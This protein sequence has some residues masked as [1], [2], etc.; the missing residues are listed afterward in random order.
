MSPEEVVRRGGSVGRGRVVLGL[1]LIGVAW[2]ANWLLPGMRTHLLFFPLWL[3]YVLAVD[4]LGRVRRG[5][6]ILSRSPRGFV[7]LFLLSVPVWWLFELMNLR[8]ENWEYVG[9]ESLGPVEYAVLCSVSFSTV[10]PAVLGT[11]ELVR[12]FSW[13][14]RFAHGPVIHATPRLC[15]GLIAAGL[16]ML[17]A[18]L[19]WPRA[20]YPLLWVSGVFLLEPLCRSLGRRSL[21]TDL[22]RGDWRPW[23]SLWTGVLICGFFWELWNF[24]SHPKWAWTS[25]ASSRCRSSGIWGTCPSHWRCTC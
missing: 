18:M 25:C 5:D 13:I 21:L 9:R 24:K 22:E 19:V 3:G 23:V 12:G 10:V 20:F 14:E 2:P 4:G 7:A 11:A 6:S 15:R 17:A 1:V 16:V 8:L